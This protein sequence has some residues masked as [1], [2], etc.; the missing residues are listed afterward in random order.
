M[1][2][3]IEL[4]NKAKEIVDYTI[5]SQEDFVELS[6]YKW[7]KSNDYASGK[8][9]NK[10]W[11]LHRYIM[12]K[13]LC[14]DITSKVPIDHIDNNRLNNTRE[15]LRIVTH[16][17]NSRNRVKK[18]NTTSQ[19]IGVC[20]NTTS[21]K[22]QSQIKINHKKLNALYENVHHA[23]HQYN[24]WCQQYELNMPKLNSIPDE[25]LE[26]FIQHKPRDNGLPKNIELIES[27]KYRVVINR[28]HIG[29]YNTLNEAIEVKENTLK[30]LE[31][32]K[33]ND[34]LSKPIERNEDGNCIINITSK[35][36]NY[37]MIVDEDNYYELIQYG[38][39]L[40]DNGY[41]KNCK[42]GYI[43][44]Y[45]MN[46]IEDHFIDHINSNRLDN[47]KSNLRVA[48]AQ[49][50]SMNTSSRVSSTSKYIGVYLTKSGKY[51]AKINGKYIGIFE[52]EIDAAKARDE[53]TKKMCRE[54]GKLNFSNE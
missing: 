1:S 15:N 3:S 39:S 52:N 43:H 21:N 26:D 24:L 13:I 34:I 9:D 36:I 20:F 2:C 25:L 53:A 8:V 42:L 5:V 45:V 28:K 51:V 37:E 41:A 30:E 47:R 18:E 22:W 17:E 35:N 48:T 12:I 54:F 32:S 40:N 50:N 6:K 23:A 11:R 27:G 49:E 14:N 31:S 7:S 44:R 4:R 16:S 10:T 19:Y 29:H 38:I 46:Y 33:L